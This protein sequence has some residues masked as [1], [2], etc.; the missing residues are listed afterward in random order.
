MSVSFVVGML[1]SFIPWY[2]SR[3]MRKS[4]FVLYVRTFSCTIVVLSMTPLS[5][6]F[7]FYWEILGICS[8]LLV[9]WWGRR[10]LARSFAIVGL[11]ASRLRDICLFLII[12]GPFHQSSLSHLLLMS[13]AIS[14]KSAQ[15][16]FFPWLLGAIEG[17]G[18]VSAL[19]HSSTLVLAGVVL[20]Y[21]LAN[22]TGLIKES[23]LVSGMGRIVVGVCRR[24][25]LLDLKIR[26]ACSTV[27]NVGFIFIWM[28]LGEISML[29]IHIFVHA[30]IKSSTFIV[31]GV[32][33][34]LSENQ[35]IRTFA[36]SIQ[37]HAASVYLFL[38]STLTLLPLRVRLLFLKEDSVDLIIRSSINNFL[39]MS[40]FTISIVRFIFFVEFVYLIINHKFSLPVTLPFPSFVH[41]RII[42]GMFL[43]Y[44]VTS[45]WSSSY[46]NNVSVFINYSIM[47][48]LVVATSYL[49]KGRSRLHNWQYISSFN[50][51][52]LRNLSYSKTLL[53]E[54]E[55]FINVRLWKRSEWFMFKNWGH[56]SK[57]SFRFLFLSMFTSLLVCLLYTL[58]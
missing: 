42:G 24:F 29:Y 41:S 8:Y 16:F 45:S 23:L 33:S 14:S 52:I 32:S 25:L 11:L 27:Y 15:M 1:A 49:V 51:A 28:Y 35:D 22:E 54:V 12:L 58:I 38:S 21:R 13:L 30:I 44:W 26:V 46:N 7:L 31:L 19:L 3:E 18:P 9:S 48:L 2:M 50:S 53:M 40:I 17:P 5:L 56:G 55:F 36:R 39:F 34:H 20:A 43:I 37:K 47:L 6:V 57:I 4:W 10:D